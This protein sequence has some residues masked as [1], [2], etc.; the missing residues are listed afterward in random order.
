MSVDTIY[1]T[2]EE[3]I[4]DYCGKT[5]PKKQYYIRDTFYG[6]FCCKQCYDDSYAK[7]WKEHAQ[8]VGKG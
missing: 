4:C 5:I 1:S 3:K 6:D 8:M 2:T 7:D